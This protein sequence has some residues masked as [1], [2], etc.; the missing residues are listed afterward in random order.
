MKK[1]VLQTVQKNRNI[2]HIIKKRGNGIGHI[3]RGNCLLTHIIEGKIERTGRRGR[4]S[5]QLQDNLKKTRGYQK[6]KEGAVYCTL[7][8]THFARGY[9]AVVGQTT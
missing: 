3:L 1:E 2:I 7:W 9:G 4:R 6:L 8:R 5:K